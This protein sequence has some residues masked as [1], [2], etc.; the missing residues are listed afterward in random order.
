MKLGPVDQLR[1]EVSD[2]TGHQTRRLTE[3]LTRDVID[4]RSLCVNELA[5]VFG[6]GGRGEDI[7]GN[8]WTFAKRSR[9]VGGGHSRGRERICQ[10]TH[11]GN[12]QYRFVDLVL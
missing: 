3:Q 12:D 11:G 6:R 5:Q 10:T 9:G 2:L 7:G 1:E 4:E 8:V